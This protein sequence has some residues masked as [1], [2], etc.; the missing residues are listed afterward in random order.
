MKQA[1]AFGL[2]LASLSYSFLFDSLVTRGDSSINMLWVPESANTRPDW[3]RRCCSTDTNYF[4]CD[5]IAGQ[6]Y[7]G[8]AYSYGGEDPYGLF[9]RKLSQGLLAGS[10]DCHYTTCG[11]PSDSVAGTDCSGFVCYLWNEPRISTSAMAVSNRYV[12][13]S[14]DSIRDGDALVRSGYHSLVVIDASEAPDLLIYESYGWPYNR[15]RSRQITVTDA[16]WSQYIALRNPNLNGTAVRG[17]RTLVRRPMEISAATAYT[18]AG[19]KLGKVNRPGVYVL[20]GTAAAG[21]PR[22]YMIM[23]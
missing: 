16:G 18:L 10:H 20:M 14:K 9:R 5:F 22:R 8:E 3:Y 17:L 7:R 2:I 4:H 15:C 12:R 6:T 23:R 19:R 11:D 21:Q 1:F 13:I